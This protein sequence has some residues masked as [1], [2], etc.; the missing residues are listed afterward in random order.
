MKKIL[1]PSKNMTDDAAL[2]LGNAVYAGLDS[3]PYFG[4][5]IPTLVALSEANSGYAAALGVATYGSRQQKAVKDQAKAAL[6]NI[7]RSQAADANVIAAGDPVKLAT[8][9]FPLSKDRQ[10]SVLGTATPKAEYGDNP[11]EIVLSTP[12]VEGAVSYKHLYTNLQTNLKKEVVCTAAKLKIVDLVPGN[13][14]EMRIVC[15]GTS[16]KTSISE[17]I[18]K[19]AV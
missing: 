5:I 6:L 14:Y 4:T 3:S 1:T 17:A 18:T 19:M 8:A 12:A 13:V 11:G 2:A 9:G 7:L 10:P 15:I 16:L